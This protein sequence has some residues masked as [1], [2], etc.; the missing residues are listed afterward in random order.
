MKS[1]YKKNNLSIKYMLLI[2]L[3]SF[4][5]TTLEYFG[6][7]YNFL[8]KTEYVISF[9]FVFIYSYINTNNS[10]LKGYKI[11]IKSWIK[12]II[13]LSIIN[14]ITLSGLSAKTLFYYIVLLII[15]LL[16][17]I[18]GKNKRSK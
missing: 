11:G 8:I 2:I 1:F 9:I 17:G 6:A 12:I 10:S 5:F 13:I 18:I 15:S 7:N 14:I 4:L 3:I 16:G